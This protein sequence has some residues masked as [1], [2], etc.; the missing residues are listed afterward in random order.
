M[1]AAPLLKLPSWCP[2]VFVSTLMVVMA[3]A[4]RGEHVGGEGYEGVE[5]EE[6]MGG[7]EVVE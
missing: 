5:E 1:P 3:A 2:F 6:G 4:A 7:V